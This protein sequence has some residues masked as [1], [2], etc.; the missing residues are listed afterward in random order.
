MY[1]LTPCCE[2]E[3]TFAASCSVDVILRVPFRKRRWFYFDVQKFGRKS[4]AADTQCRI[5]VVLYYGVVVTLAGTFAGKAQTVCRALANS[6]ICNLTP[7]HSAI[8]KTLIAE[9]ALSIFRDE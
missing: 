1:G 6:H 2:W 4:T 3:I 9:N 5:N 7:W 8:N